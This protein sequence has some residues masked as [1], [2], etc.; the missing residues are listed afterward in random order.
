MAKQAECVEC[1]ASVEISDDAME[2]EI[3]PCGDCGAEL[4]VISLDPLEIDLAPTEMEDWG[5]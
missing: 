2:G 5:E 3:I 4:E 1:G